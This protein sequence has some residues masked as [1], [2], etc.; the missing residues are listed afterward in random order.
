MST[1]KEI[2]AFLAASPQS[3]GVVGIDLI[4]GKLPNDP[5]ACGAVYEYG[6]VPPD[7]GFGAP[8]IQFE[9]PAV[10]IVFRGAPHDYAG[11]RA[12]AETAYRALAAVEVRLLSGTFYRWIHPQQAPFL[13]ARDDAE[14]VVI[15]CNFLL[16]KNL[17]VAV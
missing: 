16:E 12:K 10:Q 17:S 9:T 15:A 14:R 13:L 5:D 1:L 6:G 3:L 2:A 4:V 8:G 7:L 11:P